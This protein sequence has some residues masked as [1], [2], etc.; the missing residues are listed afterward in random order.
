[1]PDSTH[2]APSLGR[3]ITELSDRPDDPSPSE[4]A[5]LRERIEAAMRRD[6]FSITTMA[7]AVMPVVEAAIGAAEQR[8]RGIAEGLQIELRAAIKAQGETERAEAHE[9][10]EQDAIV[11]APPADESE[12]RPDV[13]D[14]LYDL[15]LNALPGEPDE[16]ISAATQDEIRHALAAVL[17]EIER[18]VRAQVAAGLKRAAAGRRDY[19]TRAPEHIAAELEAEARVFDTAS[20]VATEPSEV[21]WG[22]LPADMWTDAD[23]PAFRRESR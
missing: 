21:M 16:V 22:L 10:A 13:P 12:P 19:A 14:D 3:P 1:M 20:R 11:F 7:D 2:P 4:L 6:D 15:A 17:P 9:R 18:R 23:R 5:A 8:Y